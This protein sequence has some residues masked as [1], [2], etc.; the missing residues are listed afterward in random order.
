MYE[1]NCGGSRNRIMLIYTLLLT[2]LQ[3]N[4]LHTHARMKVYKTMHIE[5]NVGQETKDNPSSYKFI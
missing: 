3:N 2:L 4:I 5:E 1:G